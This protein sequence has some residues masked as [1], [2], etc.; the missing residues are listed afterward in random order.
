VAA[1]LP[2]LVTAGGCCSTAI[3]THT[4]FHF[5]TRTS[6]LREFICALPPRELF[7]EQMF[8]IFAQSNF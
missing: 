6:H 8:A 7:R 2:A 3:T 4:D 5:N 1:A